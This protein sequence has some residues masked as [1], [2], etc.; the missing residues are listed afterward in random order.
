MKQGCL[1]QKIKSELRLFLTYALYLSLL[2]FAFTAY[3]RILLGLTDSSLLPYGFCIIQALIMSKVILI[4]DSIKLGHIF[5]HKPLAYTVAYKTIVFCLLMF[6]LV[7]AERCVIGWMEGKGTE[8]ILCNF[9]DNRLNVAIA[10][11]FIMFLVF[12]FFFSVLETS[13]ALGGNKLFQLFFISR[14]ALKSGIKS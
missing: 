2:F 5:D 10:K 11:T 7:F 6:V 9:Y 4:G 1:K 12:I 8:E 14:D 3:E 13:R